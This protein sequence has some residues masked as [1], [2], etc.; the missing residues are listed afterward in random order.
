MLRLLLIGLGWLAVG[1]G[2]LGIFLPLLPTTPFVLLAAGLFARSSERFHRWLLEHRIFGPL[3]RDWRAYRSMP[4]RAKVTALTMVAVVFPISTYAVSDVPYLPW[5][6]VALG[7][8][9]FAFLASIP[10]TER[11]RGRP[12][13]GA[14]QG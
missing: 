12:S 4:R 2:A 1:L 11:L 8:V 7:V 14:E 13:A 6:L 10:T 3:I 5:G 9:L